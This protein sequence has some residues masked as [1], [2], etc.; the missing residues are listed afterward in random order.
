MTK[1]REL[2]SSD[3]DHPLSLSLFGLC[4]LA[5]S[6]DADSFGKARAFITA[7]GKRE[8]A[9]HKDR[10]KL[11]M[12]KSLPVKKVRRMNRCKRPVYPSGRVMIGGS[13]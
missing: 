3:S 7:V 6:G 2:I 10:K 1:Y 9:A 5:I 8:P 12:K 4:R 11:A 13:R